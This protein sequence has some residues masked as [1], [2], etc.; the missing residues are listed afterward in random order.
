[1]ADEHKGI[2][3]K[4]A[5]AAIISIA[6]LF[7]LFGFVT[8]INAIL[9][10]YFKICCQLS[11]FK[12]YLVTFAFYIS[13]LVISIPSGYLLKKKGFKYGIVL[14]LCLVAL[15]MFIFIPA[16]YSRTYGVFLL[17]L[18]TIG[19]GLAILQ[20]AANPYI[21]IVGPR[22]R[23]AKRFSIMGI[24]NK[25]AGMLAPLLFA[26]VVLRVND[27][28]VLDQLSQ[29]DPIAQEKILDEL[30]RRIIAPYA[31][32]GT[33]VLI[34]AFL[35]HRSQLPEVS[36]DED[37]DAEISSA[38]RRTHI[39]QFPH[40]ILGALAIFLHVGSQVIAIDTIIGYANAME[41]NL[42]E[43]KAFPSYTLFATIIGYSLGVTLVP[44]YVNQLN[45]LRIC[46][47][48]G[49]LFSCM[50]LLSRGSVYLLGHVTD[51]SIW[52]VVL[53]GLAN[54]MVWA[55]IWPLALNNLGRFTKIGSSCMIMGLCGSAVLPL[56]YGFLADK[57]D[58]RIAYVVLLPCYLYLI[59]YAFYGYRVK[60]W[61]PVKTAV[62][63][64]TSKKVEEINR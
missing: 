52:F 44:K 7:F 25:S 55:G 6:A 28:E 30:I 15:G 1:M 57:F 34:A 53:L 63:V 27:T 21:T 62:R 39:I 46:T 5:K 4:E 31:V 3:K 18:F 8:W 9:V 37:P 35:F 47:L 43:A 42:N 32:M 38:E 60:T 33:I 13:Y 41:L 36:A 24:C 50:I 23:A 61:L 14:G 49:L 40:L 59:F 17:G 19:S 56:V 26:S 29:M 16:A 45:V 54:S 48:L 58:L 10:P 2:A 22:D 11:N 51:I 12:A 64:T 20:S